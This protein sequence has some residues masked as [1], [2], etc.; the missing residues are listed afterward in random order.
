MHLTFTAYF[1]IFFYLSLVCAGGGVMLQDRKK[2]I[3]R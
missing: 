2:M 3:Y 1:P